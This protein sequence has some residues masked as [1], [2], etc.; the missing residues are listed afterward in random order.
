MEANE[1]RVVKWFKHDGDAMSDPKLEKLIMKYGIDGYGLYFACVELIAG[2]LD[3]DRATFELEH[4]AELLAFKFKMDQRRVEEIMQEA[5]GLGLFQ[6]NRSTERIA[7]LSLLKR[8]DDTTRRAVHSNPGILAIVRAAKEQGL[9]SEAVGERESEK[10]ESRHRHG[11]KVLLTNV[12]YE[13]LCNEFG[14]STIEA[15]I[16]NVN[17]Y[18]VAHGR[19]YKDYSRAIRNFIKKDKEQGS[20]RVRP[21]HL[22]KTKKCPQCNADILED[23]CLQCGWVKEQ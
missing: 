20:F 14:E 2:S 22:A 1:D 16:E 18:C 15:Y 5:V 12:G 17:D 8:L 10:K 7:C 11:D 3:T 13:K 21:V 19:S 4:D 6:Y 9:L 23:Y